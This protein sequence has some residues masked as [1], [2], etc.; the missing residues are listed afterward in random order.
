MLHHQLNEQQTRWNTI[1]KQAPYENPLQTQMSSGQLSNRL[2]QTLERQREAYS[3]RRTAPLWFLWSN[4]SQLYRLFNT[5]QARSV[6]KY[7]L[8]LDMMADY[9]II[10]KSGCS[11]GV[12]IAISCSCKIEMYV[13]WV[14]WL[15]L[16]A[17]PAHSTVKLAYTS[18]KR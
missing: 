16:F 3:I 7:K 1:I 14:C 5:R 17:Q 9:L 6:S 11:G 4:K 8:R 15:Q 13:V 18:K 10:W 2:W 12:T